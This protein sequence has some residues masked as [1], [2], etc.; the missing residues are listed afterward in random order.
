MWFN[1]IL[2]VLL[3]M[4][5]RYLARISHAFIVLRDTRLVAGDLAKE[6]QDCL[7]RDREEERATLRDLDRAA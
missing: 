1:V 3:L 5:L 2:I 4:A 6:L 7:R